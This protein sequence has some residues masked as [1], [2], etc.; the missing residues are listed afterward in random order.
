MELSDRPP[1]LLWLY[2]SALIEATVCRSGAVQLRA[3]LVF[4]PTQ[5]AAVS[6]AIRREE[7]HL[8]LGR[9]IVDSEGDLALVH[10]VALERQALKLDE[11][12]AEICR[13]ANRLDDLLRQRV[14][15]TRSLD[16]LQSECAALF[17]SSFPI[18]DSSPKA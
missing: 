9:L 3:H 6:D 15:G 17:L 1:V 16:R 7:R 2:G 11:E 18:S 12:V 4:D 13:Q 8:S 14:G 5:P 10:A